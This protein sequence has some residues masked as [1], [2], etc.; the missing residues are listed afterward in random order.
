M[1]NIRY[2]DPIAH[3]GELLT[4]NEQRRVQEPGAQ[5]A[6]EPGEGEDFH[7]RVLHSGSREG[8]RTGGWSD[9]RGEA[10]SLQDHEGL[11]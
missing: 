3:D 1:K 11:R 9:R 6:D 4:D 7:G 8:D 5:G 2:P 10:Q